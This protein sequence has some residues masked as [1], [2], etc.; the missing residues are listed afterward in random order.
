MDI[1]QCSRIPLHAT[2]SHP[3]FFLSPFLTR[4][5]THYIGIFLSSGLYTCR[6]S[7][8]PLEHLSHQI[9]LSVLC[10]LRQPKQ[11]CSGVFSTLMQPGE[12][13]QCIQCGGSSFCLDILCFLPFHVFRGWAL[14]PGMSFRFV[15]SVS[16]EEFLLGPVFFVFSDV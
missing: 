2:V 14:V 6:P 3:S 7:K 9:P 4:T 16:E 15:F 12:Q 10:E 8:L 1:D 5:S 11:H 13:L